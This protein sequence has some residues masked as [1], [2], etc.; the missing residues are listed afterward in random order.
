LAGVTVPGCHCA[1]GKV[2]EGFKKL[3]KAS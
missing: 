2:D 1:L 3:Q